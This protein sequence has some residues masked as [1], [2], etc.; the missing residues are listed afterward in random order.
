V[1]TGN[2]AWSSTVRLVGSGSQAYT[3]FDLSSADVTFDVYFHIKTTFPNNMI[4]YSASNFRYYL[5]CRSSYTINA[6]ATP[7]STQHYTHL[8]TNS[9]ALPVYTSTENT[10]C[11]VNQRDATIYSSS[12]TYPG[13]M[14]N[15]QGSGTSYYV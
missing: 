3:V 15:V 14:Y 2:G 4:H 10:G 1:T 13:N 6:A 12:I 11:P 8:G 9:F 5:T 7:A